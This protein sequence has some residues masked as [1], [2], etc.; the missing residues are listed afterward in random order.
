GLPAPVLAAHE[1]A[2][3]GNLQVA[4][5]GRRLDRLR[6]RPAITAQGIQRRRVHPLVSEA[7]ACGRPIGQC[8]A[9]VVA[10]DMTVARKADQWISDTF[11]RPLIRNTSRNS[12]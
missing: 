5:E 1:R 11:L 9:T 12:S 10:R 4:A 6:A 8:G 3:L 2:G 7:D